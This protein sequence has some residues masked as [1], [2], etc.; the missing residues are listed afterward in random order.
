[1]ADTEGVRTADD[2]ARLEY[3]ESLKL[4]IRC[5]GR[6]RDE[7][8]FWDGEGA[9]F[10][11]NCDNVA[12][13]EHSFDLRHKADMRAIERWRSEPW[14]PESSRPPKEMMLPDQADLCVWLMGEIDRLERVIEAKGALAEKVAMINAGLLQR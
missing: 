11:K 8:E 10:C 14:P 1:M 2:D 7:P 12:E 6:Y 13:M 3:L 5:L 4:C 9:L